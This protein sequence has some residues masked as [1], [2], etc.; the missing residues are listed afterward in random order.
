MLRYWRNSQERIHFVGHWVSASNE[1]LR[2][3]SQEEGEVQ[4]NGARGKNQWRPLNTIHFTNL[5]LLFDLVEVYE[6]V[7]IYL[8]ILNNLIQNMAAVESVVVVVDQET[9]FWW[10]N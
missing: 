7:L 9:T 5:C 2:P 3:R 1:I 8:L 10:V 6:F 4:Q